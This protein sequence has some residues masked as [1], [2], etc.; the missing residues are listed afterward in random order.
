M[1]NFFGHQWTFIQIQALLQQE[2]Q[3][4]GVLMWSPD[5]G[6]PSVSFQGHLD[7]EETINDEYSFYNQYSTDLGEFV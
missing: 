5:I 6:G 7:S 2:V 3:L 4:T 1:S